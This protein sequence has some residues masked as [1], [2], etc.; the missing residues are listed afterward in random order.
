MDH[1]AS[2]LR[3]PREKRSGVNS[4]FND[5][6]DRALDTI[7]EDKKRFAYWC[8]R[9]RGINPQIVSHMAAKAK[10]GRKPAALFSWLIKEHRAQQRMIGNDI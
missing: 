9:L 6:V 2:N 1:I 10:E 3:M 5:A 7:G 8:G 4:P